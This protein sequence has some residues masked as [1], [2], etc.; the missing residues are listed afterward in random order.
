MRIL[1]AVQSYFPFQDR[2]GPVVKVRALARG[3]AQRGNQITVLTADLGL[4]R[5]NGSAAN[6]RPCPWGW[7]AEENGVEAVYL[8]DRVMVMS[9]QPGRIK[10]IVP[11]E[12]ARPR[13]YDITATPEFLAV[14]R[15]V[16]ASIREESIK[17]AQ[18]GAALH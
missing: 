6:Y 17:I 11:V 13:P 5:L 10:T 7:R 15:Q 18:L 8:S 14:H 4:R 2:G 16:L 9:N 1:M 12:L 3:L